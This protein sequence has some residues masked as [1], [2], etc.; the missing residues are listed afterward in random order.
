MLNCAVKKHGNMAIHFAAM[1]GHLD[2][3]KYL[4]SGAG[5]DTNVRGRVS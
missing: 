2:I 3:V 5:V 4:I 1:R